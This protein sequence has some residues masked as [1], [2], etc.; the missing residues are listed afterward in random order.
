[1]RAT[2]LGLLAAAARRIQAGHPAAQGEDEA[3]AW[4]EDAASDGDRSGSAGFVPAQD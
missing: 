4:G 1:V 3:G 2:A